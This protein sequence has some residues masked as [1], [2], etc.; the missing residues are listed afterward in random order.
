MEELN[1]KILLFALE[2]ED[3]LINNRISWVLTFE[4][5]MFAAYTF[6][7]KNMAA[8]L[9][10]ET[11]KYVYPLLGGFIALMGAILVIWGNVSIASI[12]KEWGKFE[13]NDTQVSP[14]GSVGH[15]KNRVTNFFGLS[16]FIPLSCLAAW[17]VIYIR[18]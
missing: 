13:G 4:G 5:F 2:R 11:M 18:I 1:R 9:P 14:F 8:E 10:I 7:N 3:K 16:F 15:S 6:L 12:R 17:I